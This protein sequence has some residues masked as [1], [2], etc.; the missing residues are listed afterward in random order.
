MRK[1][2]FSLSNLCRFFCAWYDQKNKKMLQFKKTSRRTLKFLSKKKNF[3]IILQ[4]L[5]LRLF[6]KKIADGALL[7]IEQIVFHGL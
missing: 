3:Q 2:K 5:S 7:K 6:E 1:K 4:F